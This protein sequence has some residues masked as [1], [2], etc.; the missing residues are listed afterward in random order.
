MDTRIGKANTVLREVYCSIVTKRELST[1]PK[2]LA[3]R[4]VFAPILTYG[5]ES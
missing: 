3:F 2:L 4:S 5:H 1:A